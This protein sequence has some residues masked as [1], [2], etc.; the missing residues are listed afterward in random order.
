MGKFTTN[1]FNRIHQNFIDSMTHALGPLYICKATQKSLITD[2]Q[3][4]QKPKPQILNHG[5][6]IGPLISPYLIIFQR[7]HFLGNK[8]FLYLINK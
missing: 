8:H 7:L 5:E 4:Q 2:N 3:Q 6:P 1:S